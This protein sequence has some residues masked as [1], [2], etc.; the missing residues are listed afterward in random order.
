MRAGP[1]GSNALSPVLTFNDRLQSHQE[2]PYRD[3]TG[4]E[5][6]SGKAVH[7]DAD[8]E[9][10]WTKIIVSK[11]ITLSGSWKH[12]EGFKDT[13]SLPGEEQHYRSSTWTRPPYRHFTD[14]TG[15]C[16]LWSA[17]TDASELQPMDSNVRNGDS[18][19]RTADN[20]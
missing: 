18:A 1:P 16:S 9:I 10:F 8:S 14:A 13:W 3:R 11:A 17:R 2:R 12:V 7:A 5:G 4:R 15:Q 20:F 19:Q 6:P